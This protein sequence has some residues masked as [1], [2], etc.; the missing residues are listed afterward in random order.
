MVG[1][2]EREL[3]EDGYTATV[4]PDDRA[5]LAA[6]CIQGEPSEIVFRVR[7]RLGEWRH[8]EAH[9]TDMRDEQ[10][11]RGV[12]LNGRDVSERVVL[13]EELTRQAFHDGLTGLAN[14]AL[15]RDRLDQA[16]AR[17]T[18]SREP[19]AL[20]LVDLDGFKQINDNFG[21][22]V[23]DQLLLQVAARFE[24]VTRPSDTVARFGGDE[25][26]VLVE[27]GSEAYATALAGRLLERL[28][29]PATVADRTLAFGASIG[30]VVDSGD[31]ERRP[32]GADPP[33]RHRDVRRQEGRARPLRG[34]PRRDGA[35]VR[36]D[37]RARVRAAP[38]P[39]AQRVQRSTTSPRSR[40]SAAPSSGSRR[41][42]AGPRRRA[43][44]SR[45]REFIP[46]AEATGM[47]MQLGELALR[48]ACEQTA[49]WESEGLLPERFVTWV[50][51]SGTQ[52]SA[53]GID[54]LVR[55]TL[56]ET[57]VV[58][59]TARPRGDGDGDRAGRRGR[60][61]RARRA[62]GAA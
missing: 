26:A 3:H 54:K 2:Q 6:T 60:R 16:L 35:R 30:I 20:L 15:F 46:A 40:S 39:A 22:D 57:G 5:L 49:R 44:W 29:L 41:S 10:H 48:E 14:R 32:R 37:A 56:A 9:V 43:A 34:V 11:V 53:G 59:A 18:R 55:S 8:I 45:R 62:A 36:R 47:I 42:C 21:H 24:D 61:A 23:G 19:L 52:L 31:G 1:V 50:N 27:G 51:L 7:N 25:F 58:A 38:R 33:R 17:R 4:H 28:S 13:E 12:V